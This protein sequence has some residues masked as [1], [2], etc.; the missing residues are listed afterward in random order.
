MVVESFPGGKHN[1]PRVD[2]PPRPPRTGPPAR[3]DHAAVRA[4][5]AWASSCSTIMRRGGAS[6]RRISKSPPASS[7]EYSG[8]AQFHGGTVHFFDFEPMSAAMRTTLPR[9]GRQDRARRHRSDHRR[10]GLG[11]HR[12]RRHRT[13]AGDV[14]PGEVD[15]CSFRGCARSSSRSDTFQLHGEGEF[16][17]TFHLFRGG[18]E[19]K[20]NFS[21]REAGSN[22]YR[23]Q[24]LEGAL[25]WVP[26]QIRGRTCQ[27]G[28]L[29]RPHA[30]QASDGRPRPAWPARARAFRGRIRERRP[31]DVHRL[32]RDAGGCAWP[33]GRSGKNLLEWQLGAFRDRTGGGHVSVS[34]PP[35]VIADG[36]RS[37]RRCMSRRPRRGCRTMSAFSNH[38][39]LRPVP[40][41]RARSPTR[42]SGRSRSRSPPAKSRPTT[43]SS[44]S[45]AT[46]RSAGRTRVC[47]FTSPARTGRKAIA[48]SPG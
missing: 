12:Q 33:G 26:E 40:S 47:R 15:A 30:I 44:P 6:M 48:C 1:W 32:P 3:R 10:R 46:R 43:R 35:A 24:N 31:D 42:F 39:P 34:P 29:R 2:G 18:R 41:E 21:S 13:L 23:F 20:G 27:L 28:V 11:A 36:A 9:P 37:G 14:L 8:R 38:T 19:L 45:T 7:R 22:D 25:E 4:R 16:N 5:H 17:G